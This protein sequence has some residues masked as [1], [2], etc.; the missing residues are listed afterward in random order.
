MIS[1]GFKE[2]GAKGLNW[3]TSSATKSKTPEFR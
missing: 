1:A 2:V 3:R